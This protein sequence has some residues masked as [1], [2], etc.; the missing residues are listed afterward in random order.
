MSDAEL[1]NL[2]DVYDNEISPLMQKIIEICNKHKIPMMASF[3]YENN[4]ELG[5]GR[6]STHLG[7]EGR[8]DIVNHKANG[9]IRTGG[10][11]SFSYATITTTEGGE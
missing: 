4:E 3:S 1:Y 10:N 11:K 7:Y 9:V 5:F 8:K 2:E 6:C